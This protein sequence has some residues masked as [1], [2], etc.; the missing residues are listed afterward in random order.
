MVLSFFVEQQ[1]FYY[2]VIVYC[3]CFLDDVLMIVQ[4]LFV[5]QDVI[6]V[7]VLFVVCG[8]YEMFVCECIDGLLMLFVINVFV[9]CMCIGWLFGVDVNW[10]FDVWQQCVN[11]FVV[12]VVVLYGFV[13]DYVVEGDVVDFV[14]LL[15]ICYFEIDCGL[16]VI[17][18]VI[19]VEDLVMGIVNLSYY[20]L[21]L[22]VCNV[23]VM[24]LYLCGYL[25][26]M[27]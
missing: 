9:F 27:L 10:L 12:L 16:Y 21:M 18:V 17:N 24:S 5:D 8:W 6:V 1:D 11:V 23:L 7:V 13:F 20:C 26:W 22:Y 14:Y 19:V 3:E 25:W 4:L 15:M 2:F